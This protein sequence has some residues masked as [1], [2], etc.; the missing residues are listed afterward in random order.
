MSSEY[1]SL[2][3]QSNE[4]LQD[5]IRHLDVDLD[6]DGI[7]GPKEYSNYLKVNSEKTEINFLNCN[8]KTVPSIKIN[9][10]TVF[11]R[12]LEDGTTNHEFHDFNYVSSACELN[13]EATITNVNYFV[14]KNTP[15]LKFKIKELGQSVDAQTKEVVNVPTGKFFHVKLKQNKAPFGIEYVGEF[16]YK[17]KAG[18]I[19]RTG[20][21]KWAFIK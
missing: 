2:D 21:M 8:G 6:N 20:I 13:E 15:V 14:E 11:K 16:D 1:N 10:E 5:I 18:K 3:N 12:K 4:K 19:L 17:N 7:I 9:R